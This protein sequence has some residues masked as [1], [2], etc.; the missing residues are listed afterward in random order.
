MTENDDIELIS[1]RSFDL[2]MGVLFVL[3]ILL[4]SQF[5]IARVSETAEQ[6]AAAAE[7]LLERRR[8]ADRETLALFEHAERRAAAAGL[9]IAIDRTARRIAV[10]PS[11]QAGSGPAIARFLSEVLGCATGRP[12]AGAGCP[13]YAEIRVEH[14]DIERLRRSFAG[15]R[16]RG[17]RGPSA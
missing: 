17:R 11:A 2:A 13:S 9:A 15:V 12:A 8:L 10:L 14:A 16:R 7:R 6:D 4:A 3:L 1:A 5:F